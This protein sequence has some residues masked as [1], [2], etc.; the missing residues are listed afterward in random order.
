MDNSHEG[1]ANGNLANGHHGKKTALPAESH[2]TPSPTMTASKKKRLRETK[3]LERIVKAALDEGRIED[4]LGIF[5]SG[6]HGDRDK[7]HKSVKLEK[8]YSKASTKQVM[9][10]RVSQPTFHRLLY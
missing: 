5:F 3:K 8:V 7:T 10:A 4:D 1:M 6:A 9:I 2:T